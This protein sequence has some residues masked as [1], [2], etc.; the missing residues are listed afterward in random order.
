MKIYVDTFDYNYRIIKALYYLVVSNPNLQ[1]YTK[2]KLYN[3]KTTRF[4]VKTTRPRS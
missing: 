4:K 1:H 3:L 2:T